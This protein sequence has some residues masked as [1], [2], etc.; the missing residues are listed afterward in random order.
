MDETVAER[1][2]ILNRGWKQ[3]LRELR[4]KTSSLKELRRP[5]FE[6]ADWQGDLLLFLGPGKYALLLLFVGAHSLPM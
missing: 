4:E 1:V 5:N 2:K 3:S 6:A